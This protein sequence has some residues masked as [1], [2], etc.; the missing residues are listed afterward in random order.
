VRYTVVWKPDAEEDLASLWI[1]AE[2]RAAITAAADRIDPLLRTDPD[3]VGE[4]RSGNARIM[5]LGPL[6]ITFRIVDEDRLVQVLSVRVIP[7]A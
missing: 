7:R 5:F 1:A 6:A 4:S 3:G 2:D